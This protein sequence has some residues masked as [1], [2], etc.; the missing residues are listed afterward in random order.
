MVETK[1]LHLSDTHYGKTAYATNLHHRVATINLK[2]EHHWKIVSGD[3]TDNGEEYI[4]VE[5][6]L[7]RCPCPGNHDVGEFGWFKQAARIRA[8]DRKFGTHYASSQMPQVDII[9]GQVALIGLNSNPL[10]WQFWLSFARGNVGI[11]QRK[12]LAM[13]LNRYKSMVRIVYL[14]HHPFM[15]HPFM[16]LS[17]SCAVMKILANRCEALL[18]GHMHKQEQCEF[19][20]SSFDIPIIHAA[21]ALYHETEALEITIEDG[22]ISTKYVKI[23]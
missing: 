20:E 6:M 22:K 11:R 16:Q 21:G 8:F 13:F 7:H 14:H 18:F 4:K 5:P 3:I 15:R 12:R 23:I 1:I 2:Y 19:E 10:S 17:D 9:D